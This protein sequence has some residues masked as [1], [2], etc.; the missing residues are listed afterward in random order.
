MHTTNLDFTVHNRSAFH[1]VKVLCYNTNSDRVLGAY[2]LT[3]VH[4]SSDITRREMP[5]VNGYVHTQL[6]D[7]SYA[8]ISL[9]LYCIKS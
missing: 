7:T 8:L 1:T 9:D 5:L 6:E 4:S 2:R 3:V